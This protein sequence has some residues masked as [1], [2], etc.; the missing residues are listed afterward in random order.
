MGVVDQV[1][2][3]NKWIWASIWCFACVTCSYIDIKEK[4]RFWEPGH[5]LSLIYFLTFI[6][7]LFK[8]FS[9]PCELEQYELEIKRM[10][11][12]LYL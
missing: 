3:F 4:I 2:Y 7:K 10:S 9:E 5:L 11:N 12:A 8:V 6:L 1:H